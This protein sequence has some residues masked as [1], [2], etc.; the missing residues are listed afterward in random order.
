MN[1]SIITEKQLITSYLLGSRLYDAIPYD[2]FASFLPPAYRELPCIRNL[3]SDFQGHRKRLRE[4]VQMHIDLDYETTLGASRLL[5]NTLGMNDVMTRLM[6]ATASSSTFDP[7]VKLHLLRCKNES[8]AFNLLS[9]YATRLR[10]E[11]RELEGDCD[12]TLQQ[13]KSFE[14]TLRQLASP[15]NPSQ[16]QT[17]QFQQEVHRLQTIRSQLKDSL[18]RHG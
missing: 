1:P 11:I 16:K 7:H 6:T 4:R 12:T 8:E 18:G 5:A 2:Q 14:P 13:V 10:E 3:Y 9:T 15:L 17:R